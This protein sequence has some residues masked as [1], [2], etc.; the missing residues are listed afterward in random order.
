[1]TSGVCITRSA[2]SS[3]PPARKWCRGGRSA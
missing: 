2:G 1:V 3:E